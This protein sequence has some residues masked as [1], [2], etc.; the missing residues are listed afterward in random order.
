MQARIIDLNCK[1]KEY[2]FNLSVVSQ[3]MWG[4]CIRD[5]LMVRASSTKGVIITG[6]KVTIRDNVAKVMLCWKDDLYHEFTCHL[7]E[8]GRI[9]KNYKDLVSEIW[10]NIMFEYYGEEYRTQLD[11]KL[12]N[13]NK[14]L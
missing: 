9:S 3:E 2:K 13:L 5:I 1:E 12:D 14:T 6:F 4:R 8:F 10:Q 11:S 7:D